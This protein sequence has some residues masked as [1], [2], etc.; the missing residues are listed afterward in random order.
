MGGTLFHSQ[1]F[2]KTVYVGADG[3]DHFEVVPLDGDSLGLSHKSWAEMKAFGEAHGMPLSA[4]PEF[5][6]YEIGIDVPVEE[7]LAK[8]DVLRQYLLELPS[9]VV[10]RHYWLSRV[11]E[12]VRQGEAVFFCGT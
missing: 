9:E 5:L 1:E 12:W 4:W 11:V 7:V 8:Q 6:E 2:A 10:D 3:R